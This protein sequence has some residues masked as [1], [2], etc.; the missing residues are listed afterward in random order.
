MPVCNNCE[1][2]TE[3]VFGR[4]VVLNNEPSHFDWSF[5]CIGCVRDWRRRGLERDG[6]GENEIKTVLDREFPDNLGP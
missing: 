2:D 6:V 1:K 3:E 4:W 5:L